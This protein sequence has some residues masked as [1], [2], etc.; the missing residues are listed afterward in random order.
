M[1]TKDEKQNLLKEATEPLEKKHENLSA[2]VSELKFLAQK[3]QPF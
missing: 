1:L 2:T 3:R